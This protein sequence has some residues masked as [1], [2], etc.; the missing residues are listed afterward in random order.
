MADK[1]YW[2]CKHGANE[3]GCSCLAEAL[4]VATDGRNSVEREQALG[5]LKYLLH[6][7]PRGERGNAPGH[8][9]QTPGIWDRDNGALAG[10]PC[11]LCDAYQRAVLIV[12][13]P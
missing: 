9:H 3:V 7:L 12:G 10:K 4:V 1:H 2:V 8:S 13:A 5:A 6:E 11:R